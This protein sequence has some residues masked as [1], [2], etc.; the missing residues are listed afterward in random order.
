[1]PVILVVSGHTE[2][3]LL[4]PSRLEAMLEDG[5]AWDADRER[6]VVIAAT[7]AGAHAF[8]AGA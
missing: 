8:R 3:H 2:A 4:E 1:M 6:L 5:S 7:D